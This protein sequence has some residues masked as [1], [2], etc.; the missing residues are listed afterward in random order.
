[1]RASR[2]PEVFTLSITLG[3]AV[4]QGFTSL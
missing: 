4:A 2:D 1:V 3:V